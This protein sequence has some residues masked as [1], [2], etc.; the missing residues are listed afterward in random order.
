M[1]VLPFVPVSETPVGRNDEV[2][3]LEV[4]ATGLLAIGIRF[5]HRNFVRIIIFVD[6][7]NVTRIE[8]LT[9]ATSDQHLISLEIDPDAPTSLVLGNRDEKLGTTSD[10]RGGDRNIVVL[11]QLEFFP[12]AGIH[13]DQTLAIV[14]SPYESDTTV[15]DH[16]ESFR[17]EFPFGEDAD[18]SGGFIQPQSEALREES[19]ERSFG[20]ELNVIQL[21]SIERDRHQCGAVGTRVIPTTNQKVSSSATQQ[22]G[23]TQ[24]NRFGPFRTGSPG[25][26]WSQR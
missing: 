2:L 6:R 19:F 16:Q 12:G 20:T 10:E 23:D 3:Q 9:V 11:D 18:W 5:E 24:E 14:G 25:G 22:D 7:E 15:R 1:I 17:A 8:H 21:V 13:D 4:V 26:P